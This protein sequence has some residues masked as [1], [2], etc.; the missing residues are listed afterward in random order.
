MAQVVSWRCRMPPG[1]PCPLPIGLCVGC[2]NC[3]QQI[4]AAPGAGKICKDGEVQEE[5]GGLNPPPPFSPSERRLPKGWEGLAVRPSEWFQKSETRTGD[6]NAL[7]RG[8][9]GLK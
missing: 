6:S 5:G 8:P 2:Y 7:W 1:L 4:V 3:D 9:E